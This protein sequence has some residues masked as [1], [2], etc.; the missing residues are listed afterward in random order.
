MKKISVQC[1]KDKDDK[2]RRPLLRLANRM[3]KGHLEGGP[4]TMNTNVTRVEQILYLMVKINHCSNL[5]FF[6]IM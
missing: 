2:V 6:T 1:N 4:A 3:H 5:C